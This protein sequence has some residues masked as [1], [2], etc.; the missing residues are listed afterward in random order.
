M[1][2]FNWPVTT[3]SNVKVKGNVARSNL[4][5]GYSQSS[6][7][8]LNP[9]SRVYQIECV[10]RED[11]I[12]AINNFL[13]AQMGKKFSWKPFRAPAGTYYCDEFDMNPQGGTLYTLTATF[14]QTYKATSNG[15]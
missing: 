12:D 10:G 8:G 7:V 14:T 2:T 6:P 9:V 5:D 1:E 3:Q 13:I 11:E 15:I 4:G